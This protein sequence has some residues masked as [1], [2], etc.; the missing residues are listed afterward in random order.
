MR[1]L[2]KFEPA[3]RRLFV[4]IDSTLILYK[5]GDKDETWNIN[6]RL[7]RAIKSFILLHETEG[8]DGW[9]PVLWSGGGKDYARM[10][11]QRVAYVCPVVTDWMCYTKDKDKV[12]RRDG[13]IDDM[14]DEF[15]VPSGTLTWTPEVFI[16][17]WD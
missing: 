5:I 17:E 8:V 6:A 10:W 3:T 7:L 1:S 11:R 2:K 14:V 4:D 12:T 9:Y 16:D 13:L 15:K